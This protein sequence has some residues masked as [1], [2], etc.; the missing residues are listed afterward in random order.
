ML[1][2]PRP[3][4]YWSQYGLDVFSKTEVLDSESDEDIE[5]NNFVMKLAHK[6][7][8]FDFYGFLGKL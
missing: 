8:I 6:T 5:G 7:Y 2:L 1:H 4:C 3:P